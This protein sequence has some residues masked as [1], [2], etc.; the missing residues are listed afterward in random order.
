MDYIHRSKEWIPKL[1]F[2]TFNLRGRE[3][4]GALEF[5]L[6]VGYRHFDTAQVYEN[7]ADIGAVLGRAEEPRERLFITTKVWGTHLNRKDFLPSV[8]NSLR[9]LRQDYL[10]LLLIHWPNEQIPMEEVM[11][12]LQEAQRKEYCRLIGVSNFTVALLEETRQLGVPIVCNQFEYHPFL[13]QRKLVEKCQEMGLFM[14]AYSPIAR[15]VV[16]DEP[17]IQDIAANH[18]VKPTQVA[19][20]WLVQQEDVVAIPKSAKLMRIRENFDV[21]NFSLTEEEMDRVS[22]LR[23]RGMRLF[24][25]KFAPEWD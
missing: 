24:D 25:P 13:D 18:K 19:L 21:F 8:E 15:G 12:Q 10:D 23:S 11:E 2:G 5:A 9:E 7:E 16:A 4:Q 20:R 3:A 22:A 17:E 1:G 6:D 14:T